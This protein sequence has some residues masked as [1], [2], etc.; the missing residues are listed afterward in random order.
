MGEKSSNWFRTF[1]SFYQNQLQIEP[2]MLLISNCLTIFKQ[3]PVN[4]K[5]FICLKWNDKAK[6]NE[7][8]S[9]NHRRKSKLKLIFKCPII[10]T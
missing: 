2:A 5:Q 10:N 8:Y 1:L 7:L 4:L 9:N 3:R 6:G